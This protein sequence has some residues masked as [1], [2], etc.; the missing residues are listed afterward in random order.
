M[1]FELPD[2]VASD[3]FQPGDA[4][5]HRAVTERI[6]PRELRRIDGDD[7]LPAVVD[8]DVMSTEAR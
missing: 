4:I 7:Q 8:R 5:G 3:D 1:G 2:P 6:Q